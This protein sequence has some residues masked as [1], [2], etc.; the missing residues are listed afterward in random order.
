M[1][2][3]LE[4]KETKS[5]LI[6]GP[7]CQRRVNFC[8]YSFWSLESK[9][10]ASH[11]VDKFKRHLNSN[12]LFILLVAHKN[13]FSPY[14]RDYV[15]QLFSKYDVFQSIHDH[16]FIFPF[17]LWK[18]EEL[19]SYIQKRDETSGTRPTFPLRFNSCSSIAASYFVVVEDVRHARKHRFRDTWYSLSDRWCL[20]D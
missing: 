14:S 4:S 17:F 10:C 18:A 3:F 16:V 15:Y 6:S 20:N 19:L 2:F 11:A 8:I 7:L 13:R 9:S 12:N 5:V 1:Y